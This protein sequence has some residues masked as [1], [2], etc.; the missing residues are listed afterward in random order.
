MKDAS[1]L[2]ST[3][4]PAISQ[5]APHVY[6]TMIPFTMDESKISAHYARNASSLV[7]VETRGT[8]PQTSLLR[9]I[10]GHSGAVNSA[11]F[12]PD[13]KRIAS[14]SDD[15][16]VMIWDAETGEIVS[17]PFRGHE[18]GVKSISFSPDGTRV[19]LGSGD[20]AVVILDSESGEIVTGP[21]KGHR[22]GV[23][24]VAYSRDGKHVVSGSH[25]DTVIIWDANS[26]GISTGPFEGHFRDVNSVA[27][28]PAFTSTPARSGRPLV[29]SRPTPPASALVLSRPSS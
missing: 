18:E 5:S 14:G 27:F 24:S 4:A 1:E 11:S 23:Y 10:G 25:D 15:E 26:G 17:G 2:A 6:I 19:A 28:S 22:E 12:S 13:G 29:S 7:Q 8:K 21:M 20:G 16:T 3:F 9:V